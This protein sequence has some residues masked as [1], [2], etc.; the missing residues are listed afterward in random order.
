M[1]PIYTLLTV[2]CCFNLMQSINAQVWTGNTST[3]WFD[4]T[5]WST[6]TVPTTGD[7]PFIPLTPVG[8]NFP[9]ISMPLVAD[10][11][12]S[13]FGELTISANLDIINSSSLIIDLMGIF[14]VTSLASLNNNN[15]ST[16]AN[17]G[18]LIV[19]GNLL[20]Q[21]NLDNDGEMTISSSATLLNDTGGF[22]LNDGIIVNLGTLNNQATF[23]NRNILNNFSTLNNS[24]QLTINLGSLF[25]NGLGLFVGIINNSGD[26]VIEGELENVLGTI[27]NNG[28]LRLT[29]SGVLLNGDNLIN[30]NSIDNSG[31]ITNESNFINR[32]IIINN[33][34]NSFIDNNA[35]FTNEI[36]ATI[37]QFSNNGIDN[38]ENY[39]IIDAKNG[40]DVSTTP[41]S[42]GV[43]LR[44]ATDLAQPNAVCKTDVVIELDETGNIALQASDIDDGSTVDYCTIASS[45]LNIT[46]FSCSDV[47]EQ[48]VILTITDDL[49]NSNFCSTSVLVIPPPPNGMACEDQVN[50]SIGI[51]CSPMEIT[52]DI[53][54]TGNH[55]VCP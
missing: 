52:P 36:C 40:A 37:F 1:R 54:L 29:A 12:I 20:N 46:E 23:T 16:I 32:S 44:A 7:A 4:A 45:T 49:G 21:G 26:L 10:F 9:E 30:E 55:Y 19:E 51:A 22:I 33:F 14:R 17:N 8:G 53:L 34:G 24:G 15:G 5:N 18:N 25:F 2:L 31:T 35:N 42:T 3:N 11:P 47:G 50:L 28:N 27:T 48:T 39:G 41:N 6:G 13:V 38:V 43:V